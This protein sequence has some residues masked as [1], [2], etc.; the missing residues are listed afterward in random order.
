MTTWPDA[1]PV[2]LEYALALWRAVCER[3]HVA[4]G[5]ET[6]LQPYD[7]H[8]FRRAQDV[9]LDI[10]ETRPPIESGHLSH[11]FCEI[12]RDAIIALIPY[13]LDNDTT[14]RYMASSRPRRYLL[15][16]A[17]LK[18]DN[19]DLDI[20]Q[21]PSQHAPAA[22]YAGFLGRCKSVLDKMSRTI[23]YGKPYDDA[24]KNNLFARVTSEFYREGSNYWADDHTMAAAIATAIADD[25]DVPR[26]LHHEYSKM[27][28]VYG[29]YYDWPPIEYYWS[30]DYHHDHTTTF[31]NYSRL[32]C[33]PILDVHIPESSNE[34]FPYVFDS[35]GTDYV[36]GEQMI[37]D[38]NPPDED[39]PYQTT[40]P[41]E[42]VLIDATTSPAEADWPEINPS[43]NAGMYIGEREG[44]QMGFES[45]LI[46]DWRVA[47]GFQY[48]T[49]EEE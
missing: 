5:F 23:S 4:A 37:P 32:S 2:S 3:Q 41:G 12:V 36:L 46:L 11:R 48:Y 13:F 28:Y 39:F 45:D 25:T 44:V 33:I 24:G 38:E 30:A 22:E 15:T 9:F 20:S 34:L 42:S 47:G 1:S 26:Q 8:F 6:T 29:W 10:Y 35:L 14:A 49:K 31:T 40:A 17:Q 18:K 27:W 19:P 7:V 21:L 43:E 16:N